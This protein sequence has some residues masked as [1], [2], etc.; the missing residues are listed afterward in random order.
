MPI[1]DGTNISQ[2]PGAF[3]VNVTT[4]RKSLH[5]ASLTG[6]VC[7]PAPTATAA[8]PTTQPRPPHRA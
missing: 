3:P 2:T 5:Q 4:I 7:V 1:E 6:E 8:T